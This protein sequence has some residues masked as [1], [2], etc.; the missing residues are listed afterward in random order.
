MP[1]EPRLRD[2]IAEAAAHLYQQGH[3][4]PVD[5]NISARLGERYLLCTPSQKH[6]GQL[7]SQ[8][9]VKVRLADGNSVEPSQKPSSEIRMH[10][11]I[12]QNRPDVRAIV[13]AHSPYTTAL[14]VAGKSLRDPVIPETILALGHVPT[15]PYA[16]PT[17]VDVPAAVCD[18]AKMHNAFVLER[19][20]PVALGETLEQAMTRLEIV[21][22]TAK[23]TWMAEALGATT[24]IDATEHAKLRELALGLG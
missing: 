20:G 8:Q 4:A 17:T 24:P 5:G 12:Y 21:E 18:I 10:L 9:I 1:F 7:S 11:A 22:H 6:K 14:T 19:H 2:E 3:N 23:I 15:V 13:H 16:S